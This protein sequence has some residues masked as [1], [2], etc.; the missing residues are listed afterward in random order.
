M[1]PAPTFTHLACHQSL[2]S[3]ALELKYARSA[4]LVDIITKDEDV[5]RIRFEL[6]ILQDDADELR[7]LLAQEVDRSDV[8]EGFVKENLARAEDAETQLQVLE[9]DMRARE[10]ELL[11]MRAEM[12]AL[13]NTTE[14]VT[15]ALTEKLALTRELSKL[16]PELEHM[17]AQAANAEVFMAEKLALQRQFSNVQCELENAKREAQRALAKRR[18]TGVEIAQ[19]VQMDDLRRQLAKEKRARERAEQAADVSHPDLGVDEVRKELAH[20]KRA[21]QRAEEALEEAQQTTQIEDVRGDLLQEKKAKQKLEDALDSLQRELKRERKAAARAAKAA[22]GNAAVNEQAE[23]L[24]Q[25][26]AKE[27]KARVVAERATKQA[28]EEFEAQRALLNDKLTQSRDK[29]RSMREKLR[30]TETEL[31]AAQ[32][33]ASVTTEA[34]AKAPAATKNTKKRTAARIDADA[35][36]LGTPGDGPAAKRK[37]K[38]VAAVGDKS[39][40]SIT[41]FL[42][43]TTS[44]APESADEKID[45][46]KSADEGEASPAPTK[47]TK[48]PLAV[49]PVSNA[50]VPPKKAPAQRKPRIAPAL[51]VVTEEEPAEDVHAQG[52]E[53]A[54]KPVMTTKIKT[55]VV[56]GPDETNP[57]KK[58]PKIRKSIHEFASFAA[59]ANEP[60]KKKRKLGGLG[61]TLFDEEEEM[62]PRALPSRGMYGM[63]GFGAFG[64][65][66]MGG[67]GSSSMLGAKSR[68]GSTLLTALDGSGFQ[69]SPLKR[70]KK[71][72]DDTLRG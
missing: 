4:H 67:V 14:D 30:A 18:N 19:E 5:R 25:E 9:E 40:F 46:E 59:G 8:F 26:L 45:D 6:H 33:T 65:G 62:A 32:E 7:A 72:L 34:P 16:R 42:K 55:K 48:Q 15:A 13:K 3:S 58:K 20:E 12:G 52:Q 56:D 1:V 47:N 63:K 11:T 10:Q 57:A 23:E 54:G 29:L 31:V 24:S 22:D 70:A 2:T 53:N 38:A 64:A 66:K 44:A 39:T 36:A 71:N 60:V 61:R 49:Q 41:P 35:N 37:R 68:A 50:N 28:A 69:F 21:R 17:K 51:A 43:R 27:K